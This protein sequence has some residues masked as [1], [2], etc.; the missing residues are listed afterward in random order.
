MLTRHAAAL[1]ARHSFRNIAMRGGLAKAS[2]TIR[3]GFAAALAVAISQAATFAQPVLITNPQTLN[4]GA[5]SITPTAGG[6]AVNLATADITVSGTTLTVNGRH[7]IRD[8]VVQNNGTVTHAAGFMFDYSGGAGTDVV[9]GLWLNVQANPTGGTVT[10][11]GGS[12]FNVTG[13]GFAGGQGPGAGTASSNG[14]L[15]GAGGGHGGDGGNSGTFA[16]GLSYGSITQPITL[17]SGGGSYF[18]IPASAGGGAVRLIVSGA[19]TLNG[20]VVAAGVPGSSPSGS[21]AGGSIWITAGSFSGIGNLQASGGGGGGNSWGGGGGGRIAVDN[22]I[23]NFSGAIQASPGAASNGNGGAGSI[24]LA[25]ASPRPQLIYD[26]FGVTGF[27]TLSSPFTFNGDVFLRGGAL[28]THAPRDT[29]GLTFN[30]T[31][32]LTVA[33]SSSG[34][35][36][37]GKG[38]AG[39]QGPGAGTASSN[40]S[41]GGAGGGH[42]GDGGNSGTF[43]GGLS[44]GSETQP[45]TLGSGG[46]WYFASP[47]GAGG[48][49]VRLIV[50][51]ALTLNGSVVAAGIPGVSAAGAGAGGSIWIT[52]GSL[53]GTGNLQAIG[54]AGGGGAWGG[55]GGG[56]I[57][58]DNSISNFSGVIQASPGAAS[59]GNGGAGTIYLASASPRPQLIFDGFGVTGFNTL[60]SPL[61]FNGD[62]F[63][64]GGA[65]LTHAAGNTAGLTFNITGDLTV[66]DS[67]SGFNV[68]GKGFAG[69][70]GPGA[71]TASSNS[72]LGGAGGGHGGD[73]ANSGTLAGGLS[74]GSITQ[75]ITLGSGGGSYVGNPGGAGG[76]AVRLIV[77]GALTLNG[78]IVAIGVQPGPAA[79]A[80]AGGSIW[81]TAGSL[82][83]TGTLQARGGNGG[84]NSSW[85]GGG[86]GRIAVDSC[87]RSLPTANFFVFGGT[88]SQ[89]NGS[90]GTVFVDP[91]G[92]AIIDQPASNINT[93]LGRSIA[94]TYR[95]LNANSIRWQRRTGPGPNDFE[96]L[97]DGQTVCGGV[98]SGTQT[99]TLSIA[100]FATSC[101]DFFRALATNDCGS[102]ASIEAQTGVCSVEFNCDGALNQED[103]SGFLTAFLDESITAGPFGF[104]KAPCPGEP[105]PYDTLG[106]QA[107]Y[108]RDCSFNQEDLSAFITDYLTQVEQPNG[109]VPG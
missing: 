97:S 27:N 93:C 36:V 81:I 56:R 12:L 69:G 57:A 105:A 61:I 85:G 84:Q 62:V 106:Y 8:L 91:L 22:T 17:G 70:Q 95:V 41:L 103:L 14:S 109:C 49:A 31:G 58:V 39:G 83:G 79:G 53:S 9:N 73:G 33:D 54:G 25:S 29:A 78:S 74:Y 65:L 2:Q 30:I 102:V 94:L 37:T 108:N 48:G 21:G 59:F 67:S 51:G 87:V 11:Q 101:S 6:P 32:D 68:T 92:M 38:F 19:L 23:S 47:G 1:I 16:G 52:A 24:Y 10:V 88:A 13:K 72:S 96:D 55:G 4:P 100:E 77:S 71:G 28:L 44:Y 26:G 76:G 107:D 35:N 98:L 20:S 45:V 63:L 90:T 82:S 42:G 5:T 86:G 104:A 80:G 15:G 7:T 46:G 34:F 3:A 99:S 64:R 66:A 75:P 43:A 89:G 60:S 40:G 18:S 50:S